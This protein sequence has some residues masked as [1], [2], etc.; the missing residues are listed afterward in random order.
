M[1]GHAGH[2]GGIHIVHVDQDV[3][4]VG[5]IHLPGQTQLLLTVQT[6]GRGRFGL[7]L[8]Q[9]RQQHRRENGDDGNDYQQLDQGEGRGRTT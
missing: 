4:V 5:D 7:G 6:H 1:L 9:R 3:L 2:V 8:G